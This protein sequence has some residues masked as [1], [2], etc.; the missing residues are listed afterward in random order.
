MR[1]ESFKRNA[2]TQRRSRELVLVVRQTVQVAI[3]KKET[4]DVSRGVSKKDPAASY[5][6]TRLPLQYHWRWRA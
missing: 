5:S 2:G 6:P 3:E 1:R 4:P